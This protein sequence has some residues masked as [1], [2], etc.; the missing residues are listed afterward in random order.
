MTIPAVRKVAAELGIEPASVTGSGTGGR[1]TGLD[2]RA[3]SISRERAALGTEAL[4]RAVGNLTA[5]DPR[6]PELRASALYRA[7]SLT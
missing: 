2:I 1:V 7:W 3:A 5:T 4:C 6:L